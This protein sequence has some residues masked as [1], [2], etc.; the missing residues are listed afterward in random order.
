MPVAMERDSLIEP[1]ERMYLR[2]LNQ[3]AILGGKGI[4][5]SFPRTEP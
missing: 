3:H 4:Y 5:L 1:K 2:S